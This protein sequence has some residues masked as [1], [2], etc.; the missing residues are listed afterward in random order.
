MCGTTDKSMVVQ[1]PVPDT[2][3][4]GAGLAEEGTSFEVARALISVKTAV[5]D[6][7]MPS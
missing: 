1:P 3:W 5:F 2:S 4:G 7:L 6:C